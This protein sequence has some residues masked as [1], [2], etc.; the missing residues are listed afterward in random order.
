MKLLTID[1]K[2][3]LL[4]FK[5]VSLFLSLQVV[6]IH[7]GPRKNQSAD[8]YLLQAFIDE[9]QLSYGKLLF[10]VES[11]NNFFK[12]RSQLLSVFV[13]HLIVLI[14]VK[15]EHVFRELVFCVFGLLK[16]ALVL[17]GFGLFFKLVALVV[18]SRR[19]AMLLPGL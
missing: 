11:S 16:S 12:L 4:V 10:C 14:S 9:L 2:L 13:G 7:I 8:S 15:V 3:T 5:E 17:A 1:L 18:S 19:V 6:P